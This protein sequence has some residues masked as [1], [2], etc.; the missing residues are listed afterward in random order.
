MGKSDQSAAA[1][2]GSQ[3]WSSLGSVLSTLVQAAGA[4]EV[5]RQQQF[6]QTQQQMMQMPMQCTSSQVGNYV[7]TNCY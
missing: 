2:Q 3:I 5:A 4:Y 7:N 1:P 6:H